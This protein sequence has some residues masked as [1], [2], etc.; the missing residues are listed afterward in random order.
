MKFD[1]LVQNISNTD[2]HSKTSTSIDLYLCRKNVLPHRVFKS[3]ALKTETTAEHNE[4]KT[5]IFSLMMKVVPS[6]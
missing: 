5:D 2:S 6:T 4:M 1:I 3:V